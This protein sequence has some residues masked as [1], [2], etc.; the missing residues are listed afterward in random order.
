MTSDRPW[1]PN[2]SDYPGQSSGG[3][4]A[5]VQGPPYA[6]PK[7]GA[8]RRSHPSA[9]QWTRRGLFGAVAATLAG[10][11]V[12][13]RNWPTAQTLTLGS[14]NGLTAMPPQP[15][16]TPTQLVPV[17]AAAAS[18]VSAAP[19]SQVM[20]RQLVVAIDSDDFQLPAWTTILNQVG[21]PYDIFFA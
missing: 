17:R 20:L 16:R 7:H 21:T 10:I 5:A 8:T 15:G 6:G 3:N 2:A 4:N 13:S 9:A 12:L 14:L 19:G 11:T 1:P 18:T